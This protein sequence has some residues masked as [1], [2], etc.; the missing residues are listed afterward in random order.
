MPAQAGRHGRCVL[1]EAGEEAAIGRQNR[2]LI[3]KDVKRR[4]AVISVNHHF[5]AVAHVVNGLTIGAVVR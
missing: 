1:E 2:V 5:D 3:V 4:G